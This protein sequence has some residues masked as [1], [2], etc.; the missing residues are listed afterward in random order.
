M[1]AMNYEISRIAEERDSTEESVKKI[2]EVAQ[3][4]IEG[5]KEL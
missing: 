3:K 1:E 2:A 4:Y 5:M